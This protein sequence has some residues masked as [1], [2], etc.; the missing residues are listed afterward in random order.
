MATLETRL[1]DYLE[2]ITGHPPLLATIPEAQGARLPL[3][4]RSRYRLR[5]VNLFGNH[6]LMALQVPGECLATPSDYAAHARTLEE[7]LAGPVTLVIP[8]V[9]A[10]TRNRMVRAGTPFIVPGSQLFMPF[11]MVDLRER[12]AAKGPEAGQSVTPAAQCLLLYHLQQ[13]PLNGLPLRD[14]A[15]IGGYSAMM[16]TRGKDEWETNGLCQTAR[17]GRSVVIEF[18]AGGRKLWD[19]AERLFSSPVRRTHWVSWGQPG[20]PALESG[21]TALSRA[22]MIED[23]AIPTWALSRDAYRGLEA[24]GA[25]RSVEGPGDANAR[26]EEWNYQA[27]LLSAGAAVDPLSLLLSLRHH[28]EERVQQ[29]L[30]KL[31]A[32]TL[33]H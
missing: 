13:K 18:T 8:Q 4:L 17:T 12:F 25:L 2:S 19:L 3:F 5:S 7:Q 31:L 9:A 24:K 16:A 10:Y 1:A 22:T 21:F 15:R 14:I 11:R 28:A 23:D 20:L 33:P 29:Q 30:E 26:V 27:A 32:N 6:C